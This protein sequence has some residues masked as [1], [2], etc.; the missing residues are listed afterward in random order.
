MLSTN[1][2]A[3]IGYFS[4]P[5]TARAKD[6]R[7]SLTGSAGG[8]WEALQAGAHGAVISFASAAPYAAIAIWEAFRTRERRDEKKREHERAGNDSQEN[9]R[10]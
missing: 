9:L 8:I 2:A 3:V 1:C 10:R 4:L 7:L 5:R 6:T